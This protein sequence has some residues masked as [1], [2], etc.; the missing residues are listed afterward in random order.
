M[1]NLQNHT[2]HLI[3]YNLSVPLKRLPWHGKEGPYPT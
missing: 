3:R 1:E 2:S